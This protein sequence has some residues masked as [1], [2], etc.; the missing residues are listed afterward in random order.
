M[1]DWLCSILITVIVI[2]TLAMSGCV[3]PMRWVWSFDGTT[4]TLVLGR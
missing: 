2:W 3:D 1:R 4:H